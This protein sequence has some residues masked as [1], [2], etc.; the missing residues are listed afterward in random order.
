MQVPV[1]WFL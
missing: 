1:N